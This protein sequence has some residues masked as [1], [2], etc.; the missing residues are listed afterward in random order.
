[1][2]LQGKSDEDLI[3][4]NLSEK[5]A[6][7][8]TQKLMFNAQYFEE[9]ALIV[10]CLK[11]NQDPDEEYG[12]CVFNQKGVDKIKEH[13]DNYDLQIIREMAEGSYNTANKAIMLYGNEEEKKSLQDHLTK[14]KMI[15]EYEKEND[16]VKK[17]KLLQELIAINKKDNL[18]QKICKKIKIR[19]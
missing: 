5:E 9:L 12:L 14:M 10:E 15:D 17:E 1:M 16:P 7:S 3:K 19:K 6:K 8:L 13:L 4:L 18:F 2:K 11:N